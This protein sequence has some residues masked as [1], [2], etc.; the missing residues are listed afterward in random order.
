VGFEVVAGGTPATDVGDV[1]ILAS[2]A[3]LSEDSVKKLPGSANERS[4]FTVFILPW[5]TS[6]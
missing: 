6:D 4:S 1:D 5:I 3:D 2:P